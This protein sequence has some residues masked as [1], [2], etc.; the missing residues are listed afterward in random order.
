MVDM[1]AATVPAIVA[2]LCA[3]GVQKV[4]WVWARSWPGVL[5]RPAWGGGYYHVAAVL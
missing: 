5:E 2:F 3:C 4:H 1:G